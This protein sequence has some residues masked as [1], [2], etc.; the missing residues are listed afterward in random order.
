VIIEPT[1]TGYVAFQ[2]CADNGK[3]VG[4][5]CEVETRPAETEEE[6]IK[7]RREARVAA[8]VGLFDLVARHHF[9]VGN[10]ANGIQ[11]FS[12]EVVG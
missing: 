7:A 8:S 10:G 12:E 11:M 9:S 4:F 1:A 5:I 6:Q 3:K 2:R